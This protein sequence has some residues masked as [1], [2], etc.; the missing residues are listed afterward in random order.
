MSWFARCF[1]VY[2]L[3]VWSFFFVLSLEAAAWVR[4][5]PLVERV[6]YPGAL[7]PGAGLTETFKQY[8]VY[9]DAS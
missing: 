6:S 4:R 1:L 2:G 5:A 8:V 7:V 3:R 9:S